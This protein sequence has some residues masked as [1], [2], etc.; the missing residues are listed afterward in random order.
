MTGATGFIGSFLTEGDTV[1][2]M[3]ILVAT[4]RRD[5]YHA[6]ACSI[7]ENLVVASTARSQPEEPLPTTSIF[8]SSCGAGIKRA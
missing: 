3:H 6:S 8:N 1:M 5:G 7:D 2:V 4:H